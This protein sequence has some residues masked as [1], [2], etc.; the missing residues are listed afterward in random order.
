MP[1]RAVVAVTRKDHDG[2]PSVELF[3]VIYR[4]TQ[5]RATSLAP[6][7]E[8]RRRKDRAAAAKRS[9][10][11]Q[12]I[13]TNCGVYCGR[14]KFSLTKRKEQRQGTA[15][16]GYDWSASRRRRSRRLWPVGPVTTESPRAVNRGHALNSASDRSGS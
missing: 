14:A 7:I 2:V 16:K 1:V 12:V 13:F 8:S 9:F 3:V 4:F 15:K 5:W 10:L 11:P 6:H